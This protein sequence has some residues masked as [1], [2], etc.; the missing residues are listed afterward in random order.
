MLLKL[1]IML[2]SS[3]PKSSL[4]CSII[5]IMLGGNVK[6]NRFKLGFLLIFA[7]IITYIYIM[8]PILSNSSLLS[9]HSSYNLIKQSLQI[10]SE[11]H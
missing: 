4:L 1:P 2:L 11:F 9:L 5:K 8:T 6:F 10:H 3:A 7:L